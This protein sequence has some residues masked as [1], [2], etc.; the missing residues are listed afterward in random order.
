MIT[1]NIS[2]ESGVV[3]RA[4]GRVCRI[5]YKL[6]GDGKRVLTSCTVFIQSSIHKPAMP[7]LSPGVYPILP[8]SCH[9]TFS[10]KLLPKAL[11]VKRTQ[12]PLIPAFTMTVHKSQGQS[13]EKVIVDLESCRGTEAPYVMVSQATSLDGLLVYHAFDKQR[14]RRNMSQDCRAEQRRLQALYLHMLERFSADGIPM[15]QGGAHQSQAPLGSPRPA[16]ATNTM[17]SVPPLQAAPNLRCSADTQDDIRLALKRVRLS[18][19]QTSHA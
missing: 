1:H 2:V 8:D 10:H 3:N 13:L 5:C 18:T 12:C 7:G 16:H 11:A 9:F 15:S 4:V 14:I 17:R 19:S 6:N